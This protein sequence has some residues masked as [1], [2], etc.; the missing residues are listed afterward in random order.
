MKK[1]ECKPGGCS[2]I[3]CE[4]G[5]YCYNPDGTERKLQ[6]MTEEEKERLRKALSRN[7]AMP[8]DPKQKAM[9]PEAR[10]EAL[11]VAARLLQQL[12]SYSHDPAVSKALKTN[13]AAEDRF[14]RNIKRSENFE[15]VMKIMLVAALTVVIIGPIAYR[16]VFH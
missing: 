2:T 10:D 15:N 13:K 3:G 16:Y 12:G 14:K 7:A 11:E 5:H 9:S 8:P 1:P 6:P 4:G